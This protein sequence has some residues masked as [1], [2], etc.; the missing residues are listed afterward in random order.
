MAKPIRLQLSRRKGFDLQAASRAANG[1]EA[2]RVARPSVFGNPFTAAGCREAGF[3]G[4]D[5]LIAK[6]V[7]SAFRVWIDT[8]SW[9]ENWDGYE[10][11]RCRS[12][13]LA[14]IPRLRGKNL[15]CWCALD[16]PC[17]ADALLEIANRPICEAVSQPT[18]RDAAMKE[19]KR[20]E[21]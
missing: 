16:A 9:R 10:S 20:N 6:R 19:G 17:H 15:A 5:F 8:P 18:A 14:A 12:L 11:E 21:R 1:L 13:M 2:V 3:T 4:G 7:V